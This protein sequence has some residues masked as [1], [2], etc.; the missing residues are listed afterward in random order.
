MKLLASVDQPGHSQGDEVRNRKERERER[1]L[2]GGGGEQNRQEGAKICPGEDHQSGCSSSHI[3]ASNTCGG[4]MYLFPF[5][6]VKLALQ[7]PVCSEI[8]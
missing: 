2:W 1:G 3:R 5:S 4:P 8:F 7:S 6:T